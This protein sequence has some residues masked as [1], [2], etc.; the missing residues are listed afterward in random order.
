[1]SLEDRLQQYKEQALIDQSRIVGLQSLLLKVYDRW[2]PLVAK[3]PFASNTAVNL[4]EE[5]TATLNHTGEESVELVKALA[6]KEVVQGL[7]KKV[8]TTEEVAEYLLTEA[9]VK[10]LNVSNS[11]EERLKDVPF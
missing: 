7:P 9:E 6:L 11:T 1:M 3:Q 10:I 5:V 4:R 2:W 8:W